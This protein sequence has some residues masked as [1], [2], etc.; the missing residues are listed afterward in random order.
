MKYSLYVSSIFAKIVG[1]TLITFVIGT[2]I[3]QLIY[4]NH[5]PAL[6]HLASISNVTM[7]LYLLGLQWHTYRN[8]DEKEIHQK[9]FVDE[10][11]NPL[12]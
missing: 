7:I 8:K 9:L 3:A 4:K 10:K 12:Q 6:N 11:N 5:P 1:W 2:L